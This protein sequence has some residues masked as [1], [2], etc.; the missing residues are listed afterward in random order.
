MS[1]Q[2]E[3]VARAKIVSASF[4]EV[5]AIPFVKN[6]WITSEAWL[7]LIQ[8]EVPNHV[9]NSLDV[10]GFTS[11]ILK[12]NGIIENSNMVN[13]NGYYCRSKFMKLTG[14][15]AQKRILCF[16][17]TDVNK[18]PSVF[19]KNWTKSIITAIIPSHVQTRSQLHVSY[20]QQEAS[21]VLS[22]KRKQK[23]DPSSLSASPDATRPRVFHPQHFKYGCI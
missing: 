11:I 14:M 19:G 15:K 21:I 18:L 17:V 23:S 10:R 20:T 5:A 9:I 3:R 16:C 4:D 22:G 13:N 7:K 8:K 6:K 1:S 12:Y 2:A